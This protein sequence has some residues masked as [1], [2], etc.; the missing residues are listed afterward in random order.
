M[1]PPKVSPSRPIT[2]TRPTEQTSE[3]VSLGRQIAKDVSAQAS[4]SILSPVTPVDEE[5]G[6]EEAT[7]P[8]ILVKPQVLIELSKP[9]RSVEEAPHH[10]RARL[11]RERGT[12]PLD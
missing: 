6:L 1:P 4:S 8:G 11:A 2:H 3:H 5:W 9:K 12:P 7:D 10:L